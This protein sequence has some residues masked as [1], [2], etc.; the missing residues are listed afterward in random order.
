M[1]EDI[2]QVLGHAIDLWKIP[3]HGDNDQVEATEFWLRHSTNK[4]KVSTRQV[5]PQQRMAWLNERVQG[6][7]DGK[8]SLLARF[9][10]VEANA[11]TNTVSLSESVQQHIL[12][13]FGLNLAYSYFKSFYSGV[14]ALPRVS[15]SHLDRRPYAFCFGPKRAGIWS[16]TI[17]NDVRSEPVSEGLLFLQSSSKKQGEDR[18]KGGTALQFQALIEKAPWNPDIV[19]SPTFPAYL[20]AL[21]LSK[22]I[23]MTLA[24]IGIKV[25]AI[26]GR[27]GYHVYQNRNEGPSPLE[28]GKLSA[29]ASG[30]AT[31]LASVT[32]K[33]KMVEKLLDFIVKMAEED[34]AYLRSRG[35]DAADP[36]T[37]DG[38]LLRNNLEVLRERW[39]ADS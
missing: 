2:Y 35:R 15:E 1:A 33:G 29:E 3:T 20:N 27:T 4:V 21:V 37:G 17:R 25:R 6:E 39:D 19:R 31:K 9:I 11:G 12:H 22:E 32:R 13:K 28:L 26:E 10:W 23:S 34:E 5:S 24:D 14:Y 30:Y 8:M 18:M 38:H 36:P 7:G 16:H